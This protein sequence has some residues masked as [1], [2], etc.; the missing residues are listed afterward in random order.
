MASVDLVAVYSLMAVN[1]ILYG[2]MLLGYVRGRKD[3]PAPKGVSALEAFSFLESSFKT[4]FPTVRDGFTWSEVVART[5]IANPAM[6]VDWNKV[7]SA[8]I[9]YEAFRYGEKNKMD[10]DTREIVKLGGLLNKK[11]SIREQIG[12]Y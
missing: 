5:R 6:P 7:E 2:F 1:V 12:A 8:V 11:K 3:A 10:I 9:E 4:N